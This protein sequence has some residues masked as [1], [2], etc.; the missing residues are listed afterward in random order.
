MKANMKKTVLITGASGA[1]GSELARAIHAKGYS[2]ALQYNANSAAID[3]LYKELSQSDVPILCI[4]ADISKE[5]E[6]VAMHKI[7]GER[8]GKVSAL[9]N[10]AGVA[11]PQMLFADFD[12]KDYYHV[13][14]INVLG[15]MLCIKHFS[16]DMI[17]DKSGCIINVSSI[18]G[19]IGGSCEALYSASKAAVIG[20]TKALSKELAPS[21]VRVNCIA[22]GFVPS[23]M[24]AHLSAEEIDAI[25][26]ETPLQR[27]ISTKDIS[28]AALYLLEAENVTGQILSIDGGWSV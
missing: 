4:K 20:L 15:T 23:P 1:I 5:H 17:F 19:V 10:N 24:N 27:L 18:W 2:V 11:L 9:I 21:S 8:L 16:R 25:R 14:D 26:L 28:D 22:P 7:I 13:F 6:V 3:K 12:V